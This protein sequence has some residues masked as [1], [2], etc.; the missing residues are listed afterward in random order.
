[1][2]E[3]TVSTNPN[4]SQT[5]KETAPGP[6]QTSNLNTVQNTLNKQSGSGNSNLTLRSTR[7]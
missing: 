1:M 3:E 7:N 4:L 2:I 5:P 6:N